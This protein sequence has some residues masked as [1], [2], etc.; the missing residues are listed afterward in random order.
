MSAVIVVRRDMPEES[1]YK[2]TKAI[3]SKPIEIRAGHSAGK[4]WNLQKTLQDPPIPFHPGAIRYFKEVGA[5][6]KK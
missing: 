2:I 1:V 5:W 4:D 3:F 6:G